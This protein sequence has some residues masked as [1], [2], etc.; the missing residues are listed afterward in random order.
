MQP[1]L[2][3]VPGLHALA[4]HATLTPPCL[5]LAVLILHRLPVPVKLGAGCA[6]DLHHMRVRGSLLTE[7]MTL[8]PLR[9]G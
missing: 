1:S 9:S 5:K 7:R 8:R 2:L 3:C 4:R 6:E